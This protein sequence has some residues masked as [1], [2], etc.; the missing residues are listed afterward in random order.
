MLLTTINDN[1]SKKKIWGFGT[2]KIIFWDSD[3]K[4]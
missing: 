4:S 3:E 1:K 2:V